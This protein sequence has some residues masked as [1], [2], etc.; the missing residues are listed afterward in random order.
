MVSKKKNKTKTKPLSSLKKY[1]N[2]IKNLE[3]EI[4]DLNNKYLRL[5]AE[6]ENFKNRSESEK[7][8]LRK[9]E[10]VEVIK[11]ILPILDDFDR[12][13][14]LP[15]IKRNKSIFN[16]MNMIASKIVSIFNDIGV[17]SFNSLNKEFDIEFHEALMTKP[18]K[19]K[20][21]IVIEEFEKGYKYHDKIIR[22]A[23]VIVSE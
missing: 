18:S 15:D 20:S 2:L 9:Y 14:N 17:E 10:G 1:K 11:S 5:L 7:Y 21:N 6:F 16:G 22:H 8:N 4:S 23:K 12:T 19:K 3:I 13:L